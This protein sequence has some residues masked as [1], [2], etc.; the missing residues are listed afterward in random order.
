MKNLIRFYIVVVLLSATLSWGQTTSV[1]LSVVDSD[2][3]QWLNGSWSA[4][5]ISPP[6]VPCCTYKTTAGVVVPNQQQ[7]GPLDGTGSAIM[8]LTPNA[9]IVP[10]GTK[11]Q[12][13]YCPAAQPWPCQTSQ[14]AI[15]GASQT[16]SPL[17]PPIRINLTTPTLVVTAYLDIEVLSS[18]LGSQY[19]NLMD[20]STHICTTVTLGVCAY[21]SGGGGFGNFLNTS[22]TY[23]LEAVQTFPVDGS[24]ADL[25]VGGTLTDPCCNLNPGSIWY[26]A[27]SL[28]G[29]PHLT[30]YDG[31]VPQPVIESSDSVCNLID[32]CT[33]TGQAVRQKNAQVQSLSVTDGIQTWQLP[34]GD[35][36]DLQKGVTTP[37]IQNSPLAGH[38]RGGYGSNNDFQFSD[39]GD[40]FMHAARVVAQGTASMTTASIG[41]TACGTTV[42]VAATNVLATDVV[43]VSYSAAVAGNPAAMTLNRWATSGNVNFNYC[44]PSNGAIT[45]TATTVI[46]QVIR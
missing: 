9:S 23:G 8:T 28:N 18:T 36:F 29:N 6:G 45:P 13:Q 42:T 2:A 37:F 15:A 41:S 38:I 19:Y 11:W 35:W 34:T 25:V 7:G 27:S 24:F 3:Q 5:L 44:N 39:N 40:P 33:G 4:Q 30:W 16:V 31:T 17:P 20:Q 14:V 43:N 10:T 22:H 32:N 12:F 46:W 26:N 21:T 1:T